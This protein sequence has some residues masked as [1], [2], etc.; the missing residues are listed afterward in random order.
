M[1]IN[2]VSDIHLDCLQDK[3]VTKFA[4]TLI[5]NSPEAIVVSGDIS[6]ANQLV[7]HLS[8]LEKVVQRP[9]Y[10]VLGNHDFYGSSIDTVRTQMKDVTN[11]SQYLRY[12][13]MTPYVALT[14]ST[15]ML[16][17]D[18][19]YDAGNGDWKS[20]RFLMTDWE[21]I[22]EF[23]AVSQMSRRSSFVNLP[24]VVKVAQALARQGVQHIHDSIKSAT[25]YHKNI[26]IVTHAP[27]FAE[28][29]FHKGSVGDSSAQPW[30]T[31]K[32]LGDVLLSASKVFPNVQF[33]VLCGH[34]HGKC[35]KQIT[36]NLV[37]HVADAEY[38]HPVLQFPVEFL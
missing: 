33:T 5:K 37:V 35:S 9:I 23:A 6:N 36:H 16:G 2:W 10:Y 14:S 19:W 3:Q 4:E 11:M 7:Y 8:V 1:L 30:F 18:C 31:N 28:T 38:G 21:Y 15:A 27:P 13:S 17:H 24:E 26:I 12:L 32:M 25:R 29:H 20:S 22:K 34:T